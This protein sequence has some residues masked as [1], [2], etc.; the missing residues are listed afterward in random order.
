[1]VLL[2][3]LRPSAS[4]SCAREWKTPGLRRVVLLHSLLI[5]VAAAVRLWLGD[6]VAGLVVRHV[7]LGVFG[8]DGGA[9]CDAD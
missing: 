6:E 4:G 5:V 9:F 2:R 1:M 7:A 3:E 8:G